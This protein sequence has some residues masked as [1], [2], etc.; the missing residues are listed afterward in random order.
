[1]GFTRHNGRLNSFPP[2]I[3][4][5][6]DEIT[7]WQAICVCGFHGR[8]TEFQ[9]VAYGEL[10]THLNDS[11]NKLQVA[12]VEISE[13]DNFEKYGYQTLKGA[14]LIARKTIGVISEN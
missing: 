5:D 6:D 1:M 13:L 8:E 14:V 3:G 7:G 9:S 12:L 4:G 2:Y 11:M 10:I